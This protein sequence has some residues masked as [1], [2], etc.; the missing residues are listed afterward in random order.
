MS[1]AHAPGVS[2]PATVPKPRL[3][4][5]QIVTMSFGFMGIQFGFALQNGNTSRILRSFGA[6]VDQLPLFWLV[7][8]LVGMIVQPLIGHYSDRTWNRLGRRKPYFLTGALLSTLALVLLPNSAG[9]AGLLPALWIG[10]GFVMVMDA[11]FNIA[12]EPFRA[13]VA[14]N[15]PDSQRTLG[16]SV[17]TFLIGLGAVVASYLPKWLGLLGYSLETGKGGGVADNIKYSFY[18]GAAVFIA[19]ILV[20]VIFSKEY[21]PK[22]YEKY[23]GKPAA[24]TEKAGLGEILRDFRRMPKT[25]KQLGLVQFFSWFAMFSMWVFTT[26]AIATHVYGLTGNYSRSIAYNEAGNEVSAAFGVYNFVAMLYALCLPAIARKIGRKSTH[27][28]SLI[29]G[30]VGL[31]SIFFIRDPAMLKYSMIGVGLAWASILAMPY[32]ILSGCIPAGKMGIY[33]GIFNFFITLPQII[34]G[35]FGG[36]VVKH[37][38]GN[39]YIYAIVLAGFCLLAAA[40]CV[41]FVYDEA[42]I[43]FRGGR[44]GGKK[45]VLATVFLVLASGAFSQEIPIVP[46]VYPTNWWVGMKNP[47]LQL[48]IHG[49]NVGEDTIVRVNYPGVRLLKVHRAESPNYLFLDLLISSAAKPGRMDIRLGKPG[50]AAVAEIGYTLEPRRP[51][52]G[53]SY[54]QG[55]NSSDLIY[56]LMPDRFSDGDTSNDRV[57]DMR[58]Q[59]LNRDSIFLR[60]GGDLQG[61][62]NHLDYIQGLGATTVWLTPVLEND[63]PRRT[64]HGYS[65]TDHYTIDPRLGGADAYRKLADALHHR[66]MKL[67]QDAVYNHVGLYHFFVQDLPFKDWLHQW[68]RFTQTTYRDQPLM[69]PHASL[70]DKKIMSDG[71]F[72]GE[73]PDLNQDNPFVA[74]FLI[75]HAIW[76]V[77]EFGVDGWRIDTYMYCDLGFMNRCNQALTDEYPRITMVGECS[78][79]GVANQAY[80]ADNTIQTPFKSNLPGILDFQFVFNGIVNAL[81]D[82]GAAAADGV[83]KLYTTLASDFLYKDPTRN[84][85]FLDN[86]DMSRFFSKVGEDVAKQ[87]IGI[88]W[89]LT[90][91]GIPQ[92]YYGTE[93]L[94]KGISNPDGWVRLDLPGGW[95]GDKKNAFTGQ[96]LST[97]EAAVQG[98]VKQLAGFRKNSSALCWGK[99]MQYVPKKGLYVYFRYDARQTIMCVMNTGKDAAEVDPGDYTERVSGFTKGADVIS[100]ELRSLGEKTSIPAMTMWVMELRK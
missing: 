42:D 15:L 68:P 13:L 89:L 61:V 18:I 97:D 63:M 32:V 84:V 57:P 70:K 59:S 80:F 27:A 24:G 36:W 56:F 33:M 3:T 43:R 95:A 40:V 65:I 22:E 17:Q 55:V 11:S 98:L 41:L 14:D 86:H 81:T 75:Q 8:P 2:S 77:E 64:E 96:G 6:D 67:M 79:N 38:Y 1:L 48:M 71:W 30:G 53:R 92:L 29:A 74:N 62:I 54:A 93:I 50:A 5:W 58:D 20:T 44:S 12:M 49:R 23:H 16:F 19:A 47:A 10:A 78:V 87:K 21:P 26:D 85:I 25:M 90:C 66:G 9:L 91:R 51:G 52:N 69:D 83:N 28:F 94:M 35:L 73:M 45:M 7:A 82:T 39:Q 60:H 99:L 88:E 34:N 37:I 31:I 100:G 76:C 72:T 46:K 4:L